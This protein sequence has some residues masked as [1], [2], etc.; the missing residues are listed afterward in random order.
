LQVSGAYGN[1]LGCSGYRRGLCPR[2][3]RLPR[4]RA[5]ARLLA[6][7]G[8]RIFA[9]PA[10][11]EAVVQ[12][13]QRAWEQ[14]RQRQ[15]TEQAD[16]ERKL[17]VVNQMTQRLIDAIEQGNGEVAELNDRLRQRRKEKQQLEQQLACLR[18]TDVPPD[19]PPGREWVES[20]LRRLHEVLQAGG[21][22]ANAV[23]RQLVGGQVL[24]AEAETPGRKRRHQVFRFTL[25]TKALLTDPARSEAPGAE[26]MALK[27]EEVVV[28]VRQEPP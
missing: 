9:Q 25:S 4:E 15:P 6:A 27:S 8:E 18:S 12:E 7:V 1:Y 17:A 10:W 5:E 3:T 21:P 24:V 13:A 23:L 28:P 26:A 19:E 11:L 14:R 2:K 16:V 22:E 20:Q